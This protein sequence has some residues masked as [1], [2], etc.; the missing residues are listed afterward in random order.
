MKRLG[1]LL[2]GRG[3]N[4][5]AIAKS[6]REGRLP[7]AEIA[8]VIANV[9]DAPGLKAAQDL[10]LPTAVFVSKGRKRAEHDADVA[11]CLREHG[12]DLVIL[13]GYMRLLSP[14]F[15]AAFPNRILNIHPSLL[16]AFP[17]LDAQQQ[18]FDYGC[19][20]AGCT[21]HFVDEHLDHGVIVLQRSIAVLE[22]DDAHSLSN[23]ILAEEHVAYSEAIARVL[24]GE[25]RIEGRR[26][27]RISEAAPTPVK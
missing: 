1:I 14:E 16:P 10:G 23:R 15:I 6:I 18:A 13:A 7:N 17:G 19:K 24:S 25:Y 11:A 3:S 2:S 8:I 21:V 9:A 20:V 12:V 26:Y 5:L 22:T 4:F 27:L